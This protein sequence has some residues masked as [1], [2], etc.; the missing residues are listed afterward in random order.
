MRDTWTTWIC[1]LRS[2]HGGAMHNA[3]TW[4]SGLSETVHQICGSSNGRKPKAFTYNVKVDDWRLNASVLVR[5]TLEGPTVLATVSLTVISSVKEVQDYFAGTSS[6]PYLN[7]R[8]PLTPPP[9]MAVITPR[10]IRL[11]PAHGHHQYPLRHFSSSSSSDTDLPSEP[12]PEHQPGSPP[13]PSLSSYLSDVK[14]SLQ[15]EPQ[16]QSRPQTLR[17]PLSFSNSPHPSS[18]T[19]QSTPPSRVAYLEEI[20]RNLSE[21]RSRSAPSPP[22][23]SSNTASAS[24]PSVS[25]QELYNRHAIPNTADSDGVKPPTGSI[26]AP[27]RESL[28][29]LRSSSPG[30]DQLS[31]SRFKESLKL[32]PGE[33]ADHEFPISGV[34]D[35]LASFTQQLASKSGEDDET[36]RTQFVKMY[37]YS[38]LGAKLQMLRPEKKKGSWFSLH[39]LN[40]R[41]AKLREIEKKDNTEIVG[42]PL[43]ELRDVVSKMDGKKKGNEMFSAVDFAFRASNLLISLLCHSVSAQTLDILGHIG[44]TPSYMMHPPKDHLIEKA[45]YFHP[46]NMSSAEKL[47]LELKKVRDEYK[48]S[49]SDCGSAR[50]QVAQ[51]STKITHLGNVLSKKDKHSLHGLHLMVE[52]RKKLMKYLRKTDFDSFCLLMSRFNIRL[53]TNTK[54]L[55]VRHKKKLKKKQ[56]RK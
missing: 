33:K 21:F 37:N 50:V 32:R 16:P 12:K 11:R 25:L 2:S 29:H 31:L 3:R 18:P 7:H 47:K 56:P 24:G 13:K 54:S 36:M 43:S 53:V 51:L 15:R 40:E 35:G 44:G 28:R 38:E 22:P 48:I 52:R 23:S 20:R 10:L 41:L 55:D 6:E 49:E 42:I 34:S 5:V 4:S 39:E 14:A 1:G 9:L 45:S 17:K 46:D 19:P 8:A 30:T 27:I 26:F